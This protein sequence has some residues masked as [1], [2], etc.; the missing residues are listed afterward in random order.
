MI[1][2]VFRS[3]DNKSQRIETKPAEYESFSQNVSSQ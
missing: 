3:N 1:A 2:V